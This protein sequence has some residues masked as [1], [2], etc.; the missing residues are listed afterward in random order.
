MAS[1]PAETPNDLSNNAQDVADFDEDLENGDVT[2]AEE[3][4]PFKL[5]I[6]SYGADYTVDGLV[7]RMRR[8]DVFIPPFQRKF[9]WP[10]PK[11]SRFVESLLLGLPVPG[12]FLSREEETNKL[13]VIDGQQRLVTLRDF[14][15]GIFTPTGRRF[16]LTDLASRFD[17]LTYKTLPDDDR[18]QLADSIIHAT[19]VRQDEPSDDDSSIYMVF[20]RLNTGGM[21]LSAQ[22]IRACIYHGS[23]NELLEH[24]NENVQWR[25]IFGKPHKRTRDRELILRFL[26]LNFDSDAY[27]P[28]MKAFLNKFMRKERHLSSTASSRYKETFTR[29]IDLVHRSIGTRAF[30]PIRV[31]N[32]AAFDAVMVGLARRLKRGPVQD[33]D[34]LRRVYMILLHDDDFE[35]G[36]ETSTTTVVNV[37]ERINLAIQAFQDVP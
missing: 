29:T 24:L 10:L 4:L 12:I 27:D 13:L 22:E 1:D 18:R 16:A 3:S 21:P 17:G 28:P 33:I 8:G 32:A 2:E 36:I 11:A 5:A 15:D 26:A 7:E 19:V 9:I 31:L 37:R 20:E 14:F 23:F 30:R 35:R 6:T 25:E 34:K